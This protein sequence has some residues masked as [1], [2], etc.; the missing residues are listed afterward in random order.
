MSNTLKIGELA[1]RAGCLVETIRYY[2]REG[3]LLEPT[4]SEGNYRLYKDI[5]LERLQF[6]RHCRSLDMTLEEIRDL[7]RF[8]DAP[9]ENC[10][11]VN[12]FLDEHI[13]RVANRIK[14]LKL[15]QKNLR[16]L[17][18]LCQQ[19]RATK[20]CRI[21]Q[22]LGSSTK[23]LLPSL[24]VEHRNSRLHKTHQRSLPSSE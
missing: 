7:L 11:Q 14:E 3:L 8:R 20:D 21:L 13:E 6:I 10:S 23:S 1:K 18:N 24:N 12:A 2:E 4:R 9:D 17:R 5:H 19:T 15:L 16:G 22:S